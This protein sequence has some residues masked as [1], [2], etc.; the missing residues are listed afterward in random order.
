MQAAKLVFQQLRQESEAGFGD[1][2]QLGSKVTMGRADFQAMLSQA[3]GQLTDRSTADLDLRISC[4][5]ASENLEMPVLMAQTF[6]AGVC[7]LQYL[8]FSPSDRYLQD[9]LACHLQ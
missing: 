5:Q 1:L 4:R 8:E 9:V 3:V 6:Y 2:N 7:K